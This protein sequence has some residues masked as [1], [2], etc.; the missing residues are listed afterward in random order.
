MNGVSTSRAQEEPKRKKRMCAF[1]LI[2]LRN[3]KCVVKIYNTWSSVGDYIYSRIH[4]A[5]HFNLDSTC[6][7]KQ[8]RSY[9]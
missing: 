6:F 7:S 9:H 8:K 2:D 3:V 5:F 4:Q 1:R